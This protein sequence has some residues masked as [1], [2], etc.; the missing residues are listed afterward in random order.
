MNGRHHPST[1]RGACHRAGQFGPDPLAI[2]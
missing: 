1:G 2:A